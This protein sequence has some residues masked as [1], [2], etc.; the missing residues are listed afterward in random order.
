[1]TRIGK[2]FAQLKERGEGA[3]V[4]YVTAGD[5]DLATSLEIARAVADAGA[6]VLE[7]GVP[8]SDPVADG[9]TIQAASQRALAAGASAARVIEL[10]A[11]L[12]ESTDVPICF[13][14]YCNVVHRYG[15]ARFARDAA[16]AGVDGVLICDL[17]PADGAEWIAPAQAAGLDT[18]FMVAPTST[19]ETLREVGRRST[20]F[21]YCVSRAGITGA[22]T[23]LPPE[24]PEF[25]SRV[26]AVS[27]VPVCVGFGVSTP[28]Q[29]RAVCEVADG[30]I[31]GSAIVSL[32]AAGG[33]S[34]ETAQRVGEFCRSLRR[35]TSPA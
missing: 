5:P 3:L 24:L 33:A 8:F 29:V 7:L 17:P 14:T 21:V 22:R 30:A 10:V 35:A 6:D 11:S 23:S 13:L 1:M 15:F 25:L 20:G 2:R 26:R 19:E 28:E 4:A 12:R 18:I 9:P 16:A 32:V 31:V 27:T 34:P